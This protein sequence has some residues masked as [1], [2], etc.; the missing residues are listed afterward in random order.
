MGSSSTMEGGDLKKYLSTLPHNLVHSSEEP[1]L[2]S[3]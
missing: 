2:L 3:R 1:V